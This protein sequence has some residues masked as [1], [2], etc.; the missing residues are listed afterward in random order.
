M[1]GMRMPAVQ[2]FAPDTP[3]AIRTRVVLVLGLAVLGISSSAVLVRGMEAGPLA[4]AAWRTTGASLLLLPAWGPALRQLERRDLLGV[5]L[6]PTADE[7]S[8]VRIDANYELRDAL[9]LRGGFV[10]YQ[11][12]YNITFQNIGR[13]D[14]I[15]FDIVWSF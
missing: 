9:E 5:V 6:G 4:I 15:F 7:G 1:P 13:N 3:P 2:G 11:E 12:G 8:I 14:R 10:F